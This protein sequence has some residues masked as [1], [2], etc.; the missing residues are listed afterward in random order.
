MK[1]ITLITSVCILLL[2]FVMPALAARPCSCMK[3]QFEGLIDPCDFLGDHWDVKFMNVHFPIGIVYLEHK[4]IDAWPKHA[5]VIF[6]A[7]NNQILRYCYYADG[8]HDFALTNINGEMIYKEKPL[9]AR[10]ISA[11]RRY[12]RQIFHVFACSGP[13]EMFGPST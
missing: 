12:W 6:N 8:F 3:A 13:Q 7:F 1:K 2:A 5:A 11:L 4:D 9:P 10:V